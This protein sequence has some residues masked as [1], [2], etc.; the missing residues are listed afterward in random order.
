[1]YS[2]VHACWMLFGTCNPTFCPIH[3][4]RSLSIWDTET[5]TLRVS[6]E[7][8]HTG[9]AVAV[10]Y[11]PFNHLLM[12]T[13]GKDGKINFYDIEEQRSVPSPPPHLACV[14]AS[15]V[16][17]ARSPQEPS[18]RIFADP[19]ILTVTPPPA[20]HVALLPRCGTG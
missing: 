9:P 14:L 12:C 19:L 10:C 17:T 20:P 8:A 4:S 16:D 13:A 1:M 15:A 11:S 7:Q 18:D 3:A 5:Q 2:S 6:F